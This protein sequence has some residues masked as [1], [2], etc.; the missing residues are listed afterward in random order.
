MFW[1]DRQNIKIML[2]SNLLSSLLN[3]FKIFRKYAGLK[4]H[5]FIIA[6]L[7]VA[8][9]DGFGL[10]MFI[11]LLSF[12]TKNPALNDE[13]TKSLFEALQ[14]IGL[15]ITF[16]LLVTLIV[17]IFIFKAILKICQVTIK[18]FI[19]TD[20][21]QRLRIDMIKKYNELEYT[22][23]INTTIGYFNNIITTEI[24]RTVTS[25]AQ[26]SDVLVCISTSIVY[27]SF[28]FVLNW[29]ITILSIVA[30]L[31]IYLL[32]R[33]ITKKI[34]NLSLKVSHKN[35]AVQN[36]FIQYIHNFNSVFS[37]SEVI[38]ALT[39]WLPTKISG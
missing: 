22:Y 14:F 6:T 12:D 5:L 24:N 1:N 27:L 9:M 38:N 21:I 32:F 25:F 17:F 13:Y 33:R 35:A 30:G 23:F 16:V 19:L 7:F 31:I 28:S 2:S 3:Y 20:L 4:L 10:S 39:K 37:L 26:Y 36:L 29:K 11:P 15:E 34:A 18:S 8:V